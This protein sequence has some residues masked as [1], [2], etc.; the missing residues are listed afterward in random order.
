MWG[1]YYP[2]YE[3]TAKK[4]AS[5]IKKLQKTKN[6]HPITIEGRLIAKKWWGRAWCRNLEYYADYSNRIGRGKSYLKSGA[7]VDLNIKK[8]AVCA[9]VIG[10]AAAPYD[11]QIDIAT[12]DDKTIKSLV[13]KCSKHIRSLEDLI[14]GK[15]PESLKDSLTNRSLGLFP[16]T[17]EIDFQCSCPDNAKMCKHVAAAL[18][19]VGTRLDDD[20]LLFFE[21]RGIDSAHLVKKTIADNIDK[22][23]Q[24]AQQPSERAL[25]EQKTKQLFDL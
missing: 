14:A 15:F 19:G 3:V 8:G 2:K 16:T 7:V 11:V 21:L 24:K 10:S 18:Y 6:I 13:K 4:V 17:T 20:P 12:L 9:T 1:Y 22:L 5:T 23:L 25:D